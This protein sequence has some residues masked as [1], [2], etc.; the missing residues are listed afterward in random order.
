[1]FPLIGSNAVMGSEG[2]LGD[3]RLAVSRMIAWLAIYSVTVLIP[4]YLTINGGFGAT[5]WGTG[6]GTEYIK[7]LFMKHTDDELRK[8]IFYYNKQIWV[9]IRED[10]KSWVMRNWRRWERERPE[11]FN[12]NFK[13]KIPN[14]MKPERVATVSHVK[15]GWAKGG[16]VGGK[17]AKGG[18]VIPLAEVDVC[19]GIRGEGVESG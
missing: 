19:V 14:D 5:F 7:D 16:K 13:E 15:E 9:D 3:S 12:D 11:W 1:M 6:K 2:A 17:T 18:V 4:G 8:E 10:V